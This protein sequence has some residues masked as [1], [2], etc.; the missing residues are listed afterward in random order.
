M[1]NAWDVR[2]PRSRSP[3]RQVHVEDTHVLAA[4]RAGRVSS[5]AGLCWLVFACRILTLEKVF[6]FCYGIGGKTWKE[7]MTD[8][9]NFSNSENQSAVGSQGKK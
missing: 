9:Y 4:G 7:A 5:E 3:Q 1:E 8:E 6:I 2:T